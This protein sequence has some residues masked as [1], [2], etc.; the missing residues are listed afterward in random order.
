MIRSNAMQILKEN[1]RE[2]NGD[3]LKEYVEIAA[4]NDHNFF[5]WLFCENLENDFDMSLSE[6]QREEYNSFIQTL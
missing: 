2:S 4:E 5:R 1:L 6:E 3:N